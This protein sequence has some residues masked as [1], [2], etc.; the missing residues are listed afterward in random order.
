[1]K[2]LQMKIETPKVQESGMSAEALPT[3]MESAI[4]LGATVAVFIY[5]VF[6]EFD[7]A[8]NNNDH[9]SA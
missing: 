3:G 9:K 4:L 7:N 6:K 2:D 1:M 5:F 8:N